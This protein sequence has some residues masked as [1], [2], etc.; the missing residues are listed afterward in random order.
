MYICK[1]AFRPFSLSPLD[2]NV[3]NCNIC[4]IT[5]DIKIKKCIVVNAVC[6]WDTFDIPVPKVYKAISY[7]MFR[8]VIDHIL[9]VCVT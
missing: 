8:Q 9:K 3:I 5:F 6:R 7:K 1:E 2:M 4:L